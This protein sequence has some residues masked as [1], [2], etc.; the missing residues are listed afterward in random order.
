MIM[1][2]EDIEKRLRKLSWQS[3]RKIMKLNKLMQFLLKQN[4]MLMVVM[5][6]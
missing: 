3:V 6:W 2:K 4:R 1:T 5:I